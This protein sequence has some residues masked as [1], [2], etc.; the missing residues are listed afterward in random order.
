MTKTKSSGAAPLI[1]P[2][3]SPNHSALWIAGGLALGVAAALVLPRGRDGG[4]GHNGL[5]RTARV[6][7]GLA[8]ELGAALAVRALSHEENGTEQG[9]AAVV[10]APPRDTAASNI[11]ARLPALDSVIGILGKL[12]DRPKSR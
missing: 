3:L 9:P 8:S 1:K 12:L 10:A 11:L 5:S 7:L 6:A 2:M 4:N